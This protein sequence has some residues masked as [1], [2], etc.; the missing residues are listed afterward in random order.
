MYEGSLIHETAWAWKWKKD[1][2]GHTNGQGKSNLSN[3]RGIKTVA[4]VM[5]YLNFKKMD[6]G[7]ATKYIE[8][9]STTATIEW[10]YYKMKWS[11]HL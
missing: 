4:K 8:K 2:G 10:S 9:L 1:E 6:K 5:Q 7:I 3:S 11:I